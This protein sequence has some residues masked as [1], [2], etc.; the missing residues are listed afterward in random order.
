MVKMQTTAS[1]GRVLPLHASKYAVLGQATILR[2]LSFPGGEQH[3]AAH[4]I[5][6]GRGMRAYP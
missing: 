5:L 2:G 4:R 3:K 1:A 6:G